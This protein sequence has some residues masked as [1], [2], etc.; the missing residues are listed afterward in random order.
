MRDLTT[1]AKRAGQRIDSEAEVFATGRAGEGLQ[2]RMKFVQAKTLVCPSFLC[3]LASLALSQKVQLNTN[4]MHEK[5]HTLA[6]RQ[7][8]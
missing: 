6:G 5:T 2:H 4:T 7:A 1:L 8:L 3:C